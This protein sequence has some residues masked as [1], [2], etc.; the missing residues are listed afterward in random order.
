MSGWKAKSIPILTK[1]SVLKTKKLSNHNPRSQTLGHNGNRKMNTGQTSILKIAW[2]NKLDIS[3]DSSDYVQC[4]SAHK[5]WSST[6][7]QK[8]KNRSQTM[9]TT[10]ILRKWWGSPRKILSRASCVL[11]RASTMG[12]ELRIKGNEPGYSWELWRQVSPLN[13]TM[14]SSSY[15]WESLIMNHGTTHGLWWLRCSWWGRGVI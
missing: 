8:G 13:E 14:A 15:V 6:E 9:V 7:G 2:P 4:D 3:L 10:L 5:V 12:A 1:I 11:W